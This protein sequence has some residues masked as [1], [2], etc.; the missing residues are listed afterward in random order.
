MRHFVKSDGLVNGEK[1]FY[2]LVSKTNLY[3]S[4]K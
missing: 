2:N 4:E 3:I 1:G